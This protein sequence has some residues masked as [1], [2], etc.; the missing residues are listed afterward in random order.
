MRQGGTF[1]EVDPVSTKI[2]MYN[3]ML[4]DYRHQSLSQRWDKMPN[5]DKVQ[6]NMYNAFLLQHLEPAEKKGVVINREACIQDYDSFYRLELE[7]VNRLQHVKMPSSSGIKYVG[8][9]KE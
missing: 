9:E 4:D 3:H 5:G 8:P 1:I 2:T 6:R 7:E